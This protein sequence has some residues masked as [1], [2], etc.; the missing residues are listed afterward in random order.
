MISQEKVFQKL[1][2]RSERLNSLG[3]EEIGVFGF[4]AREEAG[5]K[6]DIDF[7]VK[8][9]EGEKSYRNHIELKDFLEE[10]F[11]TEVDLATEKS[12]KNSVRDQ[13]LKEVNYA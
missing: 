12:L 6:S 9:K 7:L 1:D 4:V 10:L 11:E 3:V 8:F 13:V 2:K 5:Q